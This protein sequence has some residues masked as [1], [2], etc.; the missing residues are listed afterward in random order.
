MA[1]E[2]TVN[3]WADTFPV[4]LLPCLFDL[5]IESWKT[6]PQPSPHDLEVPITKRFCVYL[7]NNKDRSTH[8]FRLDWDPNILDDRAT[9]TGRIDIRVVHGYMAKEY[10]SLECKLLN[11]TDR[12]GNWSSLAGKYIDEGVMRYISGQY[13]GGKNGGMIGYVMDG[14]IVEAIKRVD[15]AIENR[16][17]QLGISG[18][19]ELRQ[20]SIRPKCQQ[21]KETKHLTKNGRFT[22]HHIFLPIM[23]CN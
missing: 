21:T 6:F 5:I 20:S 17:E 19:V 3:P 7:E 1:I 10:F 8:L 4:D 22:V 11:K 15:G 9:H 16:K 13:S 18:T 12:Q 23:S 2:G 14:D